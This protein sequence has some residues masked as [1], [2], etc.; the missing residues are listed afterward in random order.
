MTGPSPFQAT[1]AQGDKWLR[2]AVD[3]YEG[4]GDFDIAA[5]EAAIATAWYSRAVLERPD[6]FA[7]LLAAAQQGK[8][9]GERIER[10]G[11][12]TRRPR[13]APPGPNYD[14]ADRFNAAAEAHAAAQEQAAAA[15]DRLA[16]AEAELDAA[17][18]RHPAGSK[19]P[20]TAKPGV[21]PNAGVFVEDTVP[22]GTA[23]YDAAEHN[24]DAK[25]PDDCPACDPDP[26]TDNESGNDDQ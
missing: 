3:T 17:V 10:R 6:T 22:D 24:L 18:G 13:T 11:P 1:T 26:D 19:M 4:G 20:P 7:A 9:G 15:A 12:R 21:P 23:V 2:Q 16:Q 14:P 25:H 8:G 5:A